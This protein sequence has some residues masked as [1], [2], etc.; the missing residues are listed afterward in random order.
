[1]PKE[2]TLTKVCD[3][4]CHRLPILYE[5]NGLAVLFLASTGL[6]DAP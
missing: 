3:P 2:G 6:T 5:D 4:P 1:M